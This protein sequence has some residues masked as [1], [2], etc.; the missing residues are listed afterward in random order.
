MEREAVSG[1]K[2][3]ARMR[4]LLNATGCYRLTGDG[5][6]DW[7][8]NA[9]GEG[10]RLL[11]EETDRLLLGFFPALAGE[12]ALDAWETGLYGGRRPGGITDRQAVLAARMAVNPSK[13]APEDLP[14]LLRA[15]G[16]EGT[17]LEE[18]DG[19][20]ILLGRLLGVPEDSAKAW[21]DKTLPAHLA[22]T[23]DDRMCWEALDAW[24]P[25]FETLDSLQQTWEQ[26]D[27]LTRDQL[28]ALTA[29]AAET[30]NKE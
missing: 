1:G 23:W 18:E 16:V 7:E 6:A 2:A 5:P 10:F 27:A 13:I 19:I 22:W 30:G 3:L 17:A 20:R 24:V 28:D 25:N 29:S 14:G 21:L 26:L 9:C 4:R 8:T 11:E 12:M 15:A